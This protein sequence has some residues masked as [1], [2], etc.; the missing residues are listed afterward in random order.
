MTQVCFD[1]NELRLFIFLL[2]AVIALMAY[3]YYTKKREQLSNVNLEEGLSGQ[4]LLQRIKSLKDA[5]YKCQMDGQMCESNLQVAQQELQ[6]VTI[7]DNVLSKIYNPLIPPERIYPGG[8]INIASY[9]EY[10]LVGFLY[11]TTTQDRYPLYGR[12]KYPGRSEKYEYYIIDE[13]RNK[14]KIPFKTRNDNELYDGDSVLVD[15]LGKSLT[16]KIY[17]Y[18]APR[19]NPTVF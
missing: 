10:Q 9:N 14:L 7:Q 4:Q 2:C 6:K 5:L 3:S 19:Y 1:Q 11:D 12:P 16:A 13:S 18:D 17:E 15:V 8:R